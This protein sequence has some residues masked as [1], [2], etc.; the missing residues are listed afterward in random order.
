MWLRAHNVQGMWKLAL[1][2]PLGIQWMQVGPSRRLW[3]RAV[4][5]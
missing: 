2:S 5:A 4:S 1:F 3:L